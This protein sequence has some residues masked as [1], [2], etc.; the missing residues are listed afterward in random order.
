MIW[1]LA[2]AAVAVGCL[3]PL[4]A[5][6]NSEL[7][8][9]AGG[10]LAATFVSV[11]VSALTMAALMATTRTSLPTPGQGGPWW[12]WTGGVLGVFI[13]LAML[14]LLSRLGAAFLFALFVV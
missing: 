1:L 4:Q 14:G 11:T 12:V 2:L 8:S 3:M 7:R 5:G 13:V 6:I 9:H 10:P